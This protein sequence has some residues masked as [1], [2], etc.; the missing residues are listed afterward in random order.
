MD[1]TADGGGSRSGATSAAAWASCSLL[2]LGLVRS[3]LLHSTRD[4]A[5]LAQLLLVQLALQT[6]G[7]VSRN[8]R[9][10]RRI[11]LE[12]QRATLDAARRLAKLYVTVQALRHFGLLF[13]FLLQH[14][15]VLLLQLKRWHET[16]DRNGVLLLLGYVLVAG[17]NTDEYGALLYT[18]ILLGAALGLQMAAQ[19]STLRAVAADGE[20]SLL[21][22]AVAMVVATVMAFLTPESV[23]HAQQ[24]ANDRASADGGM[25]STSTWA[26]Y[27]VAAAVGQFAAGHFERKVNSSS[28]ASQV[29][30]QLVYT[31]TGTILAVVVSISET[32]WFRGLLTAAA[33]GLI[34][35]VLVER[36]RRTGGGYRGGMDGEDYLD[37]YRSSSGNDTGA[38]MLATVTRVLGV[39]WAKRS[40]RQMLIFLSVNVAFMFVE[41]GVGLYTNSL[42]L[43]GDAGHMLF[44]NGA[45]VIGLVASYIGQL[46]PDAKF[47][48]GYGRVE[49]LSGFLN[50]LL[51]LVV[52]FHLITEATSRFMDPPEVTTDHLLLTSIAGLAVNLVGLFFF[53]DHV[54]G[55]SHS[56]GGDS[57]G[58]GGHGH[59]H[60]SSH[61]QAHGEDASEHNHHGG[62]SNMYGVYLHV[63]ADTLGSVGVIISSVLIQL[64]EWHVADSISSAVISL[65][66]L[67]STLP[68]L[69][70]TAR[71]LLQGAPQELEG[72][73]NAALQE[74]QASVAGVE[75]IAQWNI[76]HH[77]GDTCV[78]TLHVEVAASAEEQRVLQ[79]IRAIFRRHSKL[80]KFLS[81]QVSKPQVL[82][83]MILEGA[84]GCNSVHNHEHSHGHS[85]SHS[86]GVERPMATS[87]LHSHPN[88][89]QYSVGTT[90][91]T[92]EN[93]VS[94]DFRFVSSPE[95][96]IKS[97]EAHG[98]S[99][100]HLPLDGFPQ[101]QHQYPQMNVADVSKAQ[102]W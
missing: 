52:S 3:L 69:H 100:G 10:A 17:V 93:P 102:R 59:S 22:I 5:A 63:L 44:D 40:S 78:A 9:H 86:H 28:S 54:H 98:H 26:L 50:S 6:A 49:V 87:S 7:A 41:L 99:H 96:P 24:I 35:Y 39:L 72:S 62:N 23:A 42:G 61:H 8:S 92:H 60:G 48:Y 97:H 46:P 2:L 94:D 31:S 51:L 95:L 18:L 73:V 83:S 65:L 101:T 84:N 14:T 80:D 21:S 30:A 27:L 68:L 85:H 25:M 66:I 43:M 11:L 75:R 34:L 90:M 79:Q 88:Y 70:D 89:P 12:P 55:H 29:K 91:S 56:H 1:L 58:C 36:W 53:H 38:G 82:A 19:S 76:W 47:T 16:G 13:A 33:C 74:V 37:T 15:D 81:V 4:F 77:A 57:G 20:T 71:Q 64:Y 32:G 45:L 67:G